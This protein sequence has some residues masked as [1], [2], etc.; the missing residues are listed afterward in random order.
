MLEQS[1]RISMAVMGYACSMLRILNDPGNLGKHLEHP[2]RIGRIRGECGGN[3]R[4]GTGFHSKHVTSQST[5]R[6]R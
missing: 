6:W 1:Q 5:E 3:L 4:R 2:E